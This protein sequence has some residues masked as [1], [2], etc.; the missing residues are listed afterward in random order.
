ME[1]SNNYRLLKIKEILFQETD[2][3]NEL[4]LNDIQQKL[5]QIMDD[6]NID[7]RTIRRDLDVLD[8]SG[9][10]IVYNKGKYGKN[11]YSHQSRTFELYQLR[12]LVDAI[13]SARFITNNEKDRLIGQLK[14]LTSKHMGKTLPEPIVFSQSINMDYEQIRINIDRVHRAVSRRKVVTYQYGRYNVNKDFVHSRDGELYYVEPYGLI[15]QQDFYYLIGRYQPKDEI[16]HYRLDRIRN[17]QL[18]DETFK[19]GDFQLQEYVD[20]TF[21]MFAGEEMRIKIQFQ[22]DLAPSVIDRFGKDVDMQKI[23]EHYFVL[24]TRAKVSTGLM[25]WIL[26]WGNKAKVLSPPLL[27][28]QVKGEIKKM[29]ENYE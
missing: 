19:R 16:R 15:W 20:K 28:D 12:L 24:S 18:T 1:R 10:E 22:N 29:Y 27:V 5:Q 9:F 2:D 23:D 6:T 14:Q 7:H 3:E 26:M 17:I 8:K 21:H 4:S 25:N 13:L 11:L